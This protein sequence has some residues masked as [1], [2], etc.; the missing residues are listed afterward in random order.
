[1][2]DQ[3]TL[4]RPE[5]STPDAG[6]EKAITPKMRKAVFS[7]WGD[8][9]AYC[10]VRDAEHVDHIHPKSKGGPDAIEN[11]AAACQTCNL[12]KSDMVLGDGIIAIIS[13][14][15]KKKAP[16]ILAAVNANLKPVKSRETC[17]AE[18]VD[19]VHAIESH[20]ADTVV[21]RAKVEARVAADYAEAS[22]T[23][24]EIKASR[25]R[26]TLTRLQRNERDARE[27]EG[28]KI[29]IHKALQAI[30]LCDTAIM[31]YLKKE[32][33]AGEMHSIAGLRR[34]LRRA[35][36]QRSE[37][38]I[39]LVDLGMSKAMRAEIR[40]ILSKE[41]APLSFLRGSDTPYLHFN[42]TEHP[43][44]F[45]AVEEERFRP[46]M[47]SSG[48]GLAFY[49]GSVHGKDGYGGLTPLHRQDILMQALDRCDELDAS[50]FTYHNPFRQERIPPVGFCKAV[51][52]EHPDF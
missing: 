33:A 6:R 15:A 31:L 44:I 16:A 21:S 41:P 4:E 38:S 22:K 30:G 25:L 20:E 34:V 23:A 45:A 9:C 7:A 12:L 39:N 40:D 24:I 13:A 29:E 43:E 27:R 19:A 49:M 14:K 42:R 17:L 50:A 26:S 51:P 28:L 2:P 18:L 36:K 47:K 3:D 37:K 5:L 35:P 52:S 32:E 11:Y 10:R 1:M 48:S 46:A 8:R